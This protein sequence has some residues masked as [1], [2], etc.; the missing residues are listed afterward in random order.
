MTG[1]P[2]NIVI[3]KEIKGRIKSKKF[4]DVL[5]ID[6]DNFKGFNDEYVFENGDRAVRLT[7]DILTEITKHLGSKEDLVGHI[8]GD[9]FVVITA[10]ERADNLCQEII[11]CFDFKI[12]EFYTKED[13]QCGYIYSINRRGETQKVSLMIS[14]AHVKQ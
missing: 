10:S 2:G 12:R 3:E 11:K 9:D 1:L 4:F 14:I 8:G 7:A 5:Y 6:I 13:L